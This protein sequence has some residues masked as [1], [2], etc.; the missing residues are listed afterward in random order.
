MKKKNRREL[1]DQELSPREKKVFTIIGIACLVLMLIVVVVTLVNSTDRKTIA[2]DFG[3]T[4]EYV[5]EY[6]TVDEVKEKKEENITFH[7]ILCRSTTSKISSFLEIT[8]EDAKKLNVN[9][10]YILKLDG[11]TTS[12]LRSVA[13]LI[14]EKYDDIF[15]SSAKFIPSLVYFNNGEAE[16]KSGLGSYDNYSSAIKQYFENCGYTYQEE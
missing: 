10:I 3:I 15:T 13:S 9:K 14:G 1:P 8:N 16:E 7:V 4:S 12:E 11:F 2:D 6:I 5:Y